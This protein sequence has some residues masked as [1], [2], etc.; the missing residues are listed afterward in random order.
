M[1]SDWDGAEIVLATMKRSF[2]EK[3]QQASITG[4]EYLK[5]AAQM[6]KKGEYS[7]SLDF[8]EKASE[9]GVGN[10]KVYAAILLMKSIEDWQGKQWHMAIKGGLKSLETK[11]SFAAVYNVA[12]MALQVRDMERSGQIATL[13]MTEQEKEISKRCQD[14]LINLVKEKDKLSIHHAPYMKNVEDIISGSKKYNTELIKPE[15]L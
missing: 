8:M 12:L 7:A 6:Y 11:Y 4:L 10:P 14:I 3:S 9:K 1:I 13:D 15:V 5:S 2:T